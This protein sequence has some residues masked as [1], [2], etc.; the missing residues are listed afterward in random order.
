MSLR[1]PCIQRLLASLALSLIFILPMTAYAGQACEQTI[2]EATAVRAQ[3]EMA[4]RTVERLNASGAE[5][6]IIARV[7]QDLS[8]YRQRYSH[9]AFAYR[10]DQQ[11]YVVHK[12]NDCG[13]AL[14]NIYEQG[15]GQFFM[16][17]PFLLEA[18]VSVPPPEM[19]AKLRLAIRGAQ[20]THLHEPHYNM[21]AYPWATRYQQ[22]NQ[23]VNETLARALEPQIE[24]R[25]QAQA[26]LRLKGYLPDTLHLG[27]LTRLGGRMF[28]ANI[29]FDD[30][31]TALRFSDRIQTTTA[32]SVLAF[33]QQAGLE[34]SHFVIQAVDLPAA[35]D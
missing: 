5:V 17:R 8:T 19:Q 35:A 12:L 34:S 25:E 24:S 11:W 23:W 13:T 32:D 6:V 16:D 28:K 2:P 29:A 3:L 33:L 27:P 1:R 7:G 20:V 26:W 10:D 15:M 4:A 30:H 31:P 14:S 22:S 18:Y 9:L 21:L